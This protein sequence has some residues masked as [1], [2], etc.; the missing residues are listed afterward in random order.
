MRAVTRT[1]R[2]ETT[3][4]AM[5]PSER[6]EGDAGGK[7]EGEGVVSE[8]PGVLVEA[9]DG[10][11]VWVVAGVVEEGVEVEAVEVAAE[12]VVGEEETVLVE[13]GDAMGVVL[14]G[15][16]EGK[17]TKVDGINEADKRLKVGKDSVA[18]N[19]VTEGP[20]ARETEGF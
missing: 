15:T 5:A 4:P 6:R 9:G 18:E 7:G 17:I 8:V 20:G 10:G 12:E 16:A 14:D 19:P 11:V 2:E 1:A 3:M 13:D